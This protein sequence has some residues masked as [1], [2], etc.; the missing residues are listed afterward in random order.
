MKTKNIIYLLA[1]TLLAVSCDSSQ[2][3]KTSE[4]EIPV[5]VNNVALTSIERV[6]NTN[7]TVYPMQKAEFKSEISGIYKLQTNPKSGRKYKLGDLVKTDEIIVSLEDPEYENTIAIESKKLN[8]D[9]AEQEYTKQQSLFD[10]GGVTQREMRNA[11]VSYT[12]AKYDYENSKIKLSKMKV[13]SPFGGV[14]VDLPYYTQ[15]VRILTA[16]P[17][18]TVMDFGQMYLEISLPEKYVSD[19]QSGMKVRLT[20]F[21]LQRDT[22]WGTVSDLSPAISAE[23]RTFKGRIDIENQNL[24]LKPGMFVSADIIITKKEN[25]IVVPKELVLRNNDSQYVFVIDKSIA[26]QREVTTG[27]E[28][29]NNIEILSGLSKDDRLVVKGFETLKDNSKVRVIK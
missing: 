11:E 18:F 2:E 5:S 7:G 13:A 16:Q 28:N 22:L 29:G 10:K 17:L 8:L 19:L 12:N 1:S 25:T 4:P 9:I 26:K 24:K 21:N 23:T 15:N 14:I 20:S 6:I 27:I 3:N